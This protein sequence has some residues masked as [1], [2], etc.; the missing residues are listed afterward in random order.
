[1]MRGF[2]AF[3]TGVE[4]TPIFA[5]M[6]DREVEEKGIGEY[7]GGLL[8]VHGKSRRLLESLAGI[9]RLA[10]AGTVIGGKAGRNRNVRIALPADVGSIDAVVKVF[11][12]FS[13]SGFLRGAGGSKARRTFDAAV[14]LR[15]AGVGTPAPVA[16]LERRSGG[17][18]TE[19]YFV[20]EYE[21]GTVSFKDELIRLFRQEP[22]CALF[23]ELLQRVALAVREMHDA[24]FVH[25][26][27]GNQNILLQAGGG[28]R[29]KRV[30]F[31]DLNRGRMNSEVSDRQRARDISRIYLPSD[32]LRVFKEMY[33]KGMVPGAGFQK[34]ESFYRRMYAIHAGTRSIRHPVREY[35]RS[36]GGEAALPEYPSEK[37]MWVWDSRS[38]QPV[39]VMKSRDRGR[40]YGMSRTL[41]P[42]RTFVSGGSAVWREYRHC[43]S[44]CYCREL[45]MAGGMGVAVSGTPEVFHRE[46]ESLRVLGRLPVLIRFPCWYAPERLAEI[47]KSARILHDSGHPV[48]AALLQDRRAI[49]EPGRWR[50]FVRG[51]LEQIADFVEM[52]EPGHAINRVKWGIWDLGEHRRMIEET[53]AAADGLRPVRWIGPSAIDFEYVFLMGALRNLPAGFGMTAMSHLLYVDRRGMPE[54]KQGSF[55]S[56]E[57]FALAKALAIWSGVCGDRVIVTEV[58]WPIVGT[59]VYSPV[60]SPYMSPGIRRNDPSVSENLYADYMMR[61]CLI[62]LCSGMV[63]RVYWW[64]LAAKGFGLIDPDGWR[65]RPA[66]AVFRR[67]VNVMS[68]CVFLRKLSTDG[69]EAYVFRRGDGGGLCLA[70]SVREDGRFVPPYAKYRVESA[71]GVQ[72]PFSKEVAVG[73]RPVYVFEE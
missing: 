41:I 14:F 7:A 35:R 73:S 59:D 25:Y 62:A 18:V 45:R 4:A 10:D 34:W 44:E 3:L 27:L 47:A 23:M 24:G 57:K 21:P 61:Y 30:L 63:E 66:F 37:D 54:A 65:E 15:E 68:D 46:R 6:T 72:L 36:D 38:E 43:L 55:S 58:N 32:F 17:R 20:S 33:W 49:T 16:W 52:V 53:M 9:D 11:G 69:V 71:T 8:S 28:N 67:M 2:L 19:S 1:M 56:L 40:H 31:V 70:Y 13:V 42:A 26:D 39:N 51:V 64:K 60:N 5:G 12:G 29:W 50:T 48:T 22:E